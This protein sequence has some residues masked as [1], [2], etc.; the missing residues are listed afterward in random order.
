VIAHRAR[1]AQGPAFVD[2]DQTDIGS[3]AYHF[4]Y[5]RRRIS[6]NFPGGSM[7]HKQVLFQSAAREKIL[8]GASLLADA[9][10][11]TLGPK[12]LSGI[13]LFFD[14]AFSA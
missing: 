14:R 2:Q 4:R 1:R 11:V 12:S 8:R 13:M 3:H 9:V 10:R 5:R 7:P 6:L